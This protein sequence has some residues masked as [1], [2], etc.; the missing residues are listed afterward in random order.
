MTDTRSTPESIHKRLLEAADNLMN[1]RITTVV[2]EAEVRVAGNR[3]LATITGTPVTSMVTNI[4]LV[5]GDIWTIVGGAALTA[6]HAELRAYHAGL[7]D[8]GTDIVRQNLEAVQA[9]IERIAPADRTPG[10]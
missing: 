5:E 1:L 10:A 8:R 6:D 9:L 3:S 4:N 2:G 7:V